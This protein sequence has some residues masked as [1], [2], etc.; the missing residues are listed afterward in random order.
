VTE[1]ESPNK[2]KSI[3]QLEQ[4]I[5]IKKRKLEVSLSAT[6]MELF[7]YEPASETAIVQ[8]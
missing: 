6:P 5:L 3:D 4:K 2:T 7:M 1:E 8:V